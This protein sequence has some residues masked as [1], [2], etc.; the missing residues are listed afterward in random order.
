MSV[1]YE[2]YVTSDMLEQFRTA[3][4]NACLTS[5]VLQIFK[6]EFVV[7]VSVS[8]DGVVKATGM[9]Q[10][11]QVAAAEDKA[12]LRAFAVLGILEKEKPK[13]LLSAPTQVVDLSDLIAQ[14][15]VEMC[16][17]G[18][19]HVQG[20]SYLMATYRKSSRSMLNEQELNGFLSFLKVQPTPQVAVAAGL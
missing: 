9:S 7:R 11:S 10:D 12:R 14:S 16:R 13:P 2:S 19:D 6:N 18:W 8:I 3:F 20:Q 15:D 5:E 1:F 17:L 4:P